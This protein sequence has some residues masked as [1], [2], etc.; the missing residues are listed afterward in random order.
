MKNL[1]MGLIVFMVAFGFVGM[2]PAEAGSKSS[3]VSGEVTA[4]D[5]GAKTVTVKAKNKDVTLMITDRTNIAQGKEKRTL[6]DI[7]PGAKLT[8]QYVMEGDKLMAKNIKLSKGRSKS[9]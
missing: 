7:H 1:M 8:A 6:G 2:N 4:V 9:R 5:P 3:K